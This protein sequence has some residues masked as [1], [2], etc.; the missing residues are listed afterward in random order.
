[1]TMNGSMEL[2]QW[3]IRGEG[4]DIKTGTHDSGLENF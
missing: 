3:D 4:D 2:Q 1:M